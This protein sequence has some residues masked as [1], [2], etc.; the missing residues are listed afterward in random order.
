MLY[1]VFIFYTL[2]YGLYE[3]CVYKHIDFVIYV[4]IYVF[5]FIYSYLF[6]VKINLMK[7]VILYTQD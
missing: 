4:C 5:V 7:E 2:F 1:F 3:Y 6:C